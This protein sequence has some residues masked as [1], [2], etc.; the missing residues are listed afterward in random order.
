MPAKNIMKFQPIIDVGRI[1]MIFDA[2]GGPGK[3]D[4][5][6]GLPLIG[7]F[8]MFIS[9]LYSPAFLVV[10]LA[11]TSLVSIL[12]LPPICTAAATVVCRWFPCRITTSIESASLTGYGRLL[13]LS[14]N[15]SNRYNYRIRQK[16]AGK[17]NSSRNIII[18]HH[19]LTV[20]ETVFPTMAVDSSQWKTTFALLARKT[21]NIH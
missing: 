12:E 8:L 14:K 19:T 7:K 17:L 3:K 2:S 15:Y 6:K 10:K 16:L 18:Y 13:Q 4:F 5:V 21:E 1:K 9:I 20:K 11:L